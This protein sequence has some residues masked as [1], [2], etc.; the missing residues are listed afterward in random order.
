MKILNVIGRLS[1]R[2]GGPSKTCP[3]LAGAL[4]ARGHTVDIYTTNMDGDHELDVPVGKPVNFRGASITYFQVGKPRF[5]VFSYG[6]ARALK[7]TLPAYDIVHI[8]SFY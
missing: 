1:P 5:W 8:Y 6:L 3:E 2:D 7:Q 4:A